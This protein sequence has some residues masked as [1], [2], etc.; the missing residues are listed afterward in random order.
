[1]WGAFGLTAAASFAAWIE[2]G[3]LLHW[4]RQRAGTIALPVK[5]VAGALV[6]AIAAG[7]A[8]YGA[9]YAVDEAG[10]RRWFAALVACGVFG[11][12][13]LGAMAIAR[14]PEARAFTR[15]LLRR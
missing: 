3:L 11:A 2:F 1:V 14:V 7:A 5:L 9:G 10:A 8:G 12:V 4:A 6:A 15:K 13:Y